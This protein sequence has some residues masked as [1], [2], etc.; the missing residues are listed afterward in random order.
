MDQDR[1]ER[2]EINRESVPYQAG[3]QSYRGNAPI[4]ANPYPA[5]TTEHSLWDKGWEDMQDAAEETWED[6]S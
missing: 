2:D 3:G 1:A 4:T 5:N 6:R